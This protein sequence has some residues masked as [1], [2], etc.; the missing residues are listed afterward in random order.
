MKENETSVKGG[1]VPRYLT[2]RYTSYNPHERPAVG[3]VI[4]DIHQWLE[5][6]YGLL[7][8]EENDF[9]IYI[10]DD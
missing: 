1:G 9:A 5:T 2:S 4:T 6:S 8:E 3:K 7:H 10:T